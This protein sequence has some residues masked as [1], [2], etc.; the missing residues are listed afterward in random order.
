MK[1]I[2]KI[3]VYCVAIF[4]S[5]EIKASKPQPRASAPQTKVGLESLEQTINNNYI[6]DCK[7]YKDH[8]KYLEL[9]F[10]Q[11]VINRFMR[12]NKYA[13]EGARMA[14]TNAQRDSANKEY[15]AQRNVIWASV[16]KDLDEQVKLKYAQQKSNRLKKQLQTYLDDYI[17]RCNES[18]LPPRQ[19]TIKTL[20]THLQSLDE[21]N[22]HKALKQ[23][24]S[25]VDIVLTE[26]AVYETMCVDSMKIAGEEE[27]E[28]FKRSNNY[29]GRAE[30]LASMRQNLAWHQ[31]RAR[32]NASLVRQLEADHKKSQA[33]I[34]F[35]L[36][37]T[38]PNTTG[39]GQPKPIPPHQRP[40]ELQHVDL[41]HQ[42]EPQARAAINSNQQP[43][44][45]PV[46][47]T[48]TVAEKEAEFYQAQ[49][50]IE[51]GVKIG[52][53]LDAIPVK[54]PEDL[55][56]RDTLTQTLGNLGDSKNITNQETLAKALKEFEKEAA[57]FFYTALALLQENAK[58]KME[59]EAYNKKIEDFTQRAKTRRIQEQ[60]A[61]QKKA[62]Q[63]WRKQTQ[64]HKVKNESL[65][66]QEN[67][68][69]ALLL[70]G[71]PAQS[72]RA[73]NQESAKNTKEELAATGVP[74]S[75]A[76]IKKDEV[77]NNG[78]LTHLDQLTELHQAL[79]NDDHQRVAQILKQDFYQM[80]K[81]C[82]KKFPHPKTGR[83]I[84]QRVS[85]HELVRSETMKK[86]VDE[87]W[88]VPY[89]EVL[90]PVTYAGNP[91]I[92]R[93]IT[94][95]SLYEKLKAQKQEKK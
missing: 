3:L 43:P 70:A 82:I 90:A 72:I 92:A 35:L 11:T 54:T 76:L 52:K 48:K 38:T 46:Q 67:V 41:K 68:M 36:P 4:A 23:A 71:V 39:T 66:T 77:R 37:Q 79:L 29:R 85:A 49:F 28:K 12:L 14:K 75:A 57:V 19:D 21:V 27:I 30:Q 60:R 58:Q 86:I 80:N 15:Y 26:C 31:K 17:N 95:N 18:G 25:I 87:L 59:Q 81:F 5:Y 6:L 88:G 9:P 56:T 33:R 61:Y 10:D 45:Q 47:Q 1:N 93:K 62:L 7:K 24:H 94:P 83:M 64:E 50:N 22:F 8:C 32:A 55:D 53:L 63:K 51:K 73:N 2:K 44:L 74:S 20:S 69:Q 84:E 40:Q 13:L 42:T 65:A 16:N 78:I 34:A 89:A 91:H